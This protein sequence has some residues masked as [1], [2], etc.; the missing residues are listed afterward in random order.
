MLQK[1]NL[2]REYSEADFRRIRN[3][4]NLNLVNLSDLTSK[5]MTSIPN[6]IKKLS[7]MTDKLSNLIVIAGNTYFFN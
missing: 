3:Q 2:Q 7:I 5:F 1:D 4:S 6:E